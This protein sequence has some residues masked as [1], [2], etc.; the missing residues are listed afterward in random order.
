MI[1]TTTPTV[2]GKTIREYK[3]L[4]FGETIIGANIIKDI[5]AG[6]RDIVGGRSGSYEQVL[7]EAR[8][9]A[10][11]ELQQR[12]M[13]VGANAVVGIDLEYEVI[14][15]SGSMLMVSASGTAVVVD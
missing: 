14:G 8:N 11:A 3:G 6:I 5:F 15:G 7:Q 10:M 4:V 2:E 12:A 1:L 9:T 13:A